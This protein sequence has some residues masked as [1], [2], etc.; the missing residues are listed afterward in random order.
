MAL[1]DLHMHSN[2]SDGAYAPAEVI[3]LA[4]DAGLS[5]VALT[6]HD[7][8][9]GLIEALAAARAVQASR[10]R[11]ETQEDL[12]PAFTLIPGIEI[13][14]EHAHEQHIL[15]YL[16]D[17]ED[18]GLKRFTARLMDMRRERADNILT[19]LKKKNVSLRY[20]QM[21]RLTA[22][23]YIG[24]PQIAAAMV[25]AGYVSSIREAFSRYLS[26][27][28]FRRIPRP[29]P[30]AEE[31]I[32][33]INAAGGAAVLAH[34]DSLRLVGDALVQSIRGLKEQ[35]LAG[36]ECHYGIYTRGQTETYVAIAERLGL[37]VTGGSDFHGP[38]IKP[39][40][41]IG[42]GKDGMLDFDDIDIA[43]RL[44]RAVGLIG[45]AD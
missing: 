41:L 21:Q 10:D 23:P 2:Q 36:L 22:G 18:A 30:T 24:R 26:G 40:V 6:D 33:A 7:T 1:V 44:I 39:G 11:Q 9:A 29:K 31:A 45:A 16:I 42:T 12:P 28:E 3:R 25:A 13:T 38:H 15:G 8:T 32:S 35:G 5:V 43:D 34:P 4:A 14:T 20:D 17:H 37:I 27:E 19:Y